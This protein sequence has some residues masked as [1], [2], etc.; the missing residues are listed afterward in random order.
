[1]AGRGGRCLCTTPVE[2]LTLRVELRNTATGGLSITRRLWIYEQA[3]S[4]TMQ[5]E[6]VGVTE[7]KLADSGGGSAPSG[8]V[9]EKN[10]KDA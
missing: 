8:I 1:M 10:K 4:I 6:V 9:S 3:A 7:M 2:E 5:V